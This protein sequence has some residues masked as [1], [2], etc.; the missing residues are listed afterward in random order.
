MNKGERETYNNPVRLNPPLTLELRQLSYRYDEIDVLKQLN[1]VF[2]SGVPT[3]VTG[4]SGK[5][6]TTLIR[7]VLALISPDS[8]SLVLTRGG[9]N[10]EISVATRNNIAYM[11]QGNTLFCGTIRENLL[12]ADRYATNERLEELL[13]TACAEFVYTL[14]DGIETMIGESGQGLSEGQAQRIAIARALLSGGSIWLFDEPTSSID[15]DTGKQLIRNL[16]IAGKEKIIIFVSHDRY[17]MEL[18][19][20]VVQLD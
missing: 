8:G 14:P 5:G 19:A 18:C 20:Q 16:L 1:V 17:L 13:K 15:M 2:Q 4:A 11:P 7:L 6:K 3:A 9:E 12:L 10:H